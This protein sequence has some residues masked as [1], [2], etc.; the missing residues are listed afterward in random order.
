MKPKIVKAFKQGDSIVM[1]I[2]APFAELLEIGPGDFLSVSIKDN[3]I[4]VEK[5]VI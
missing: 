5:A 4:I 2:P 1:V 3:K